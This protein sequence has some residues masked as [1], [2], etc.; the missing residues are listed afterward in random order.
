VQWIGT[1]SFTSKNSD[2]VYKSGG[3]QQQLQQQKRKHTQTYI[4]LS[5][6]THT[7]NVHEI[8]FFFRRCRH[9]QCTFS[10]RLSFFWTGDDECLAFTRSIMNS[11]LRTLHT[12]TRVYIFRYLSVYTHECIFTCLCWCHTHMHYQG[13]DL[14]L[15]L[16]FIACRNRR[17]LNKKKRRRWAEEE[18]DTRMYA[19]MWFIVA[20]AHKTVRMHTAHCVC[21][22]AQSIHA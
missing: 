13:F 21:V 3:K 1:H 10:F 15:F 18:K 7:N 5:F 8:Y 17:G 14:F 19:R 20:F 2:T 6:V 22:L 12:V 4:H 11:F 16:F 9:I